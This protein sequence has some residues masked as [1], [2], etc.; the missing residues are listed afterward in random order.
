MS[1]IPRHYAQLAGD[2]AATIA[3]VPDGK[4]ESPS[5]CS[6]WTARDV[7]RHIV[8]VH[9][10]FL[11]HVGRELGAIPSVDDDPAAAF[12]AARSAIAADLEDPERAR[13]S[14][15]GFFGPA[16]F[17]ES[18]DR[19]LGGDLLIHRWDLANAAGLDVRLDPD[20]ISRY[21]EMYRGF[22]DA[23]RVPEAFGPE[24][25]PPA[26]ADEQTRLLAFVGRK[27]W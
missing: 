4:W 3:A 25:E 23:M 26:G 15:E 14:Y 19:F 9:G 20:E 18:I 13:Q 6:D 2:F 27:A 16:I 11:G 24:L 7:V 12:D 21:F 22:G 8:D 10:F 1:S 5:P 17:E